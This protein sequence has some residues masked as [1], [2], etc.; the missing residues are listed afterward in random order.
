LATFQAAG[1][2]SDGGNGREL[3][4]RAIVERHLRKHTGLR[5]STKA[6]PVDVLAVETGCKAGVA[7]VQTN[8]ASRPQ[9]TGRRH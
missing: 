9:E 5:L 3:D 4:Y 7:D 2:A 8:Q 1:K 6:C